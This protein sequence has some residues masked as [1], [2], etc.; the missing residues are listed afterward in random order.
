MNGT[1][2]RNGDVMVMVLSRHVMLYHSVLK[3]DSETWY[4]RSVR[5]VC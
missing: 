4:R 5:A 3:L 2:P 1:S